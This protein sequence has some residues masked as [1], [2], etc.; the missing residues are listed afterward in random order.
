MK[1]LDVEAELGV[2][3]SSEYLQLAADG[4]LDP[5][6][7]PR[8]LMH[9]SHFELIRVEAIAAKTR[10]LWNIREGR[11]FSDLI[12]VPFAINEDGLAYVF[13]GHSGK[14]LA[15]VGF[16]QE[17]MD[18]LMML[19]PSLGDFVFR[20]LLEDAAQLE[21]RGCEGDSVDRKKLFTT[22]R[23]HAGC[24]T[25]RQREIVGRV[26]SCPVSEYTQSG[27]S[28]RGHVTMA[29]LARLIQEELGAQWLA[30]WIM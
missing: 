5:E 7:E 10:D 4:M 12:L 19:A 29:T 8:L 22:L 6:G 20:K 1:L 28:Y 24:L 30:N 26:Y 3:Y 23:A 16:L 21:D 17:D 9:A 25:K 14:A 18:V 11:A 2:T 27:I 13:L 15:H